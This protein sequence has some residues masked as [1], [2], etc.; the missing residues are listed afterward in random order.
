[1]AYLELSILPYAMHSTRL[2]DV[3]A[4]FWRSLST[5]LLT[6]YSSTAFNMPREVGVAELPRMAQPRRPA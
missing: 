3:F 1:M 5:I 6:A 4:N 2:S